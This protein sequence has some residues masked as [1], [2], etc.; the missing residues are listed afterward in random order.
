MCI[1]VYIYIVYIYA[2][3]LITYSM[4]P[5]AC[6]VL[7]TL[8]GDYAVAKMPNNPSA[9]SLAI[10]LSVAGFE[11]IL[12]VE[13]AWKPTSDSGDAPSDCPLK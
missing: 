11:S 7:W 10:P 1:Y 6:Y 8:K 5:R 2:R 4:S 13:S 9:W 3:V 12:N